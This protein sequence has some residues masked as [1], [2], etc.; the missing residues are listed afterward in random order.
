VAWLLLVLT[1]IPCRLLTLFASGQLT[2]CAGA[3]LRRRLLAGVL[4]LEPQAIRHLGIGQLL[5][6]MIEAAVIEGLTAPGGITAL[7]AVIELILAAW[8]V[9]AGAGGWL[10]VGLLG[11][12][13]GGT[14]I[15]AWCY[16]RR[17]QQWTAE[18]LDLTYQ[19]VESM[20]GH[21]TRLAQEGARHR[22]AGEDQAHEHYLSSSQAVDRQAL[23]LRVLVPR[24][25][26]I[27][28]LVILAPALIAADRST[29]SLAVSVG[30]MVLAL[31]ALRD[32]V[33]GLVQLVAAFVAW[34]R[35]RLFAGASRRREPP[36]QPEYAVPSTTATSPRQPA[37][38]VPLLEIRDVVIR[39]RDRS[40]PIVQG[41][42]LSIFPGDH[43]LLEGNSGGGK[44]TLAGL[45]AGL[46]LPEAGLL[47]LDGLD[48]ESL[49]MTGWRRRVVLAPQ[50]HDNHVFKG[51][52]AFNLLLGRGWPPREADLA[53]AARICRALDLGPLLE[54]M[55]S[56]RMQMVGEGGWQ[57]SHGEKSRLYLARAL[58]QGA[59]LLMLD[60]SFAALDPQTLQRSLASVL[61]NAP[62]LLVIAHP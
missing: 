61:T 27:L 55:P 56:G 28:S 54:R 4:Q 49:G 19:L 21:R 8:V 44:S 32:L 6:R 12:L 23:A 7:T 11:G 24:G 39:H 18:R 10:H 33:D 37:A 52:L 58:L 20:I 16:Y 45:L 43:I 51:T 40:E 9:G 26:L 42:T 48:R 1:L 22:H 59:D 38:D 30:G 47:L 50:F 31:T 13:V 29:P 53:E 3:L 62:T 41:A 60:E 35:I 36:G 15:F 2:I 46:H 25:W 5:G 57:L 34:Q 17:Q 14:L